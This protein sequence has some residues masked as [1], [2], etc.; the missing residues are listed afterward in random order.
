MFPSEITVA[1]LQFQQVFE[2]PDSEK[3]ETKPKGAEGRLLEVLSQALNFK[4]KLVTSPD[5]QW[6]H[7]LGNGT[8]NGLIGVVMREEADMAICFFGTSEE[9]KQFIDFSE[10]YSINELTFATNFP[11]LLPTAYAYMYPFDLITWLG[12][13]VVLFT[14]PI[15]FRV[16][17]VTKLP[18]SY[19]LL[20]VFGAIVLQP[21]NEKK[22][23]G[24]LLLS[25]LW[26]FA[27]W[28]SAGY[29]AVL[30]SFLSVPL[31]DTYVKDFKHLTK[32]VQ[33]GEYK[34]LTPKGTAIIPAMQ[35][36]GKDYLI[37][38]ADMIDKND[39]YV[40]SD[41]YMDEDNFYGKTA[42]LGVQLM[43]NFKFGKAP[44]ATKYI[45]NDMA[46]V[47]PVAMVVNKNFCCKN[48]LNKIIKRINGA[49]LYKRI[50]DDELYKAWFRA[51]KESL[52]QEGLLQM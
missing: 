8:W 12:I 4:Y 27:S 18:Y 25:C 51:Q 9:R 30:A 19:L 34:V 37:Y 52:E 6:G 32:V 21:I 13:L 3:G 44:L 35:N 2:F 38:I 47:L 31:Y 14:M 17:N 45:S 28:I 20:K 43:L 36:T 22:F 41:K 10:P 5:K 1:S 46:L 23:R 49:G 16:L 50:T 11:K 26:Y 24:L 42:V 7:H 33:G 29:A 40:L 39:W 15:I 48:E